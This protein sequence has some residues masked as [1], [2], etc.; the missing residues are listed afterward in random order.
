MIA[1]R[2]P[3]EIRDYKEKIVAGFTARQLASIIISLAVCI[4]FYVKGKTYFN[5]EIV[6]WI[7]IIFAMLCGSLGFYK[8]NGM[9]FEKYFI[10]ILKTLY[11]PQKRVFANGL[12]LK[13]KT[14]RI[15]KRKRELYSYKKIQK[16]RQGD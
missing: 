11:A 12:K 14:K 6:S 16:L 15:N 7:T 8:K 3:R 10:V 1:V 4:P 5:E 2:I 9:H 13:S